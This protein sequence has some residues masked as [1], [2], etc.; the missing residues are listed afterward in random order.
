MEGMTQETRKL[1]VRV[2]GRELPGAACEEYRD[3]HVAVQRGAEPDAPV[4]ADAAEAVW[5]FEVDLAPAP[6]GTQDFKGPY[7]QGG[8]GARFFY[9]TWGELP[10]G[11]RFTMFRRAKLY[12]ADIPPEALTTGSATAELTL[13]DEAGLPLC[14]AVRPPRVTWRAG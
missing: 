2:V 8:R 5:E 12:F 13:T 11:G 10:P 6:D 3:V 14:A 9:L 4:R 7:A 1:T